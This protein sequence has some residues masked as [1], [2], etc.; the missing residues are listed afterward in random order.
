MSIGPNVVFNCPCGHKA[1]PFGSNEVCPYDPP[2][3]CGGPQHQCPI[4]YGNQAPVSEVLP[5]PELPLSDE[6]SVQTFK[7][8]DISKAE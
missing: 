4:C 3:T 7:G 6:A 8:I 5:P 2:R 1:A